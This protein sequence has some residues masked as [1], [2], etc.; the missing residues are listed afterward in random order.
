M[1]SLTTDPTNSPITPAGNGASEADEDKEDE[2]EASSDIFP[3]DKTDGSLPP[4]SSTTGAS[5]ANSSGSSNA[6]GSRVGIYTKTTLFIGAMLWF[7]LA[8]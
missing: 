2:G 3:W 1:N 7:A 5:N 6:I 4:P 8:G